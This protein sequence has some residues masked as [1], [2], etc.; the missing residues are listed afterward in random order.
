MF[1]LVIVEK[2]HIVCFNFWS[3]D[4]IFVGQLY[5]MSIDFKMK[6]DMVSEYITHLANC[7][8]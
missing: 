4:D 5:L 1:R 7:Q 2:S 8:F 6:S 3:A